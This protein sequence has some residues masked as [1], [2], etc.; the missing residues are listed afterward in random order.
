MA[1][2]I[3]IGLSKFQV[4]R[5]SNA[6]PALSSDTSLSTFTIDGTPAMDGG[7]QNFANDT[8]SVT[9]VATPT[10]PSAIVGTISGDN[11]LATG[12]NALTFNVTAE[13]G[14]TVQTYDVTLHVL[15]VGVSEVTAITNSSIT[16]ANLITAGSGK[17]FIISTSVQA[18]GVWFNTGTETEPNFSGQGATS[19]LEVFVGT[20]SDEIAIMEALVASLV[21]TGEF[22][23]S[24]AGGETVAN[25][26][27]TIQGGRLDA[28]DVDSGLILVTTTQGE[29][30]V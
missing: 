27:N 22:T 4:A 6:S 8:T 26:T 2:G 18:L 30:P 21:G 16:S 5:I 9:V 29:N 13:D 17:G 12:D 20:L 25:L 19:Y 14:V 15:T 3:R 10:H 11:S 23:S 1:I 24:Y 7:V 28:T